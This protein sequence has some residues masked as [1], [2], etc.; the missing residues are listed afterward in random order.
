MQ[1]QPTLKFWN[2]NQLP[3]DWFRRQQTNQNQAE[4]EADIK[5]IIN[6]VRIEGDQALLD[7]TQKFDK[8]ILTPTT[9]KISPSE[10]KEAYQQ[11]T[12]EQVGAIEFMKQRVSIFQ[13]QLLTQTNVCAFN[14][15]IMVQ[16]MLQPLESVGCYVPGGQAAYPSTVVM[17]ALVAK[18]AGVKRIVICSP[19]NAE[20]KVNPLVLVA[21]DICGIS[22]IYRVGGAQAIAALAYGTQTIVPV[23]KIV[24]PGSKYVTAA[25]VIVSQDI[26]IDMPAGPSEVLIIADQYA[27]ARLIAYDMI[28]Q[29]EHGTDSVSGLITPSQKLAQ[30]VQAWLTKLVAMTPRAEKIL[31]SLTKYGFIIVCTNMEEAINLTNQFAAEH[32]EVMTNDAKKLSQRLTAGL[33]LVGPYSSVPLSDYASGTNHVLP[34]SGFAQS[35]SGLSAMDFMRRV[36]IV[37]CSKEGLEKVRTHVKVLTDT[38]NL[39]NHSKAIDARFQP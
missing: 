10:I 22:E 16:T 3:P 4:L 7:F 20:G 25:K 14:E 35:F 5:T 30:D 1:N 37:E 39:P 28:S 23:H 9:I 31:G 26:A 36:S 27:D 18:I 32:L 24:G 11:V 34:T 15:G 38:E 8:A 13:Q 2:S 29:A 6:R 33:I 17:T 21:A 12:K 19:S